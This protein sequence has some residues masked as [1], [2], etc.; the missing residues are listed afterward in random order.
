VID[1]VFFVY[2]VI[3]NPSQSVLSH[4]CKMQPCDSWLLIVI[5]TV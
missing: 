1:V 2:N 4:A 3:I 5:A